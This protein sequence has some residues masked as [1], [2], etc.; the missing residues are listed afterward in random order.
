MAKSI[1]REKSYGFAL[2]VIQ[3]YK[4]LCEEHKEYTLSR[5][6]LKA[7]TSTGANIRE[8]QFAQS[9]PDMI[10][11]YSIALKEI[12]EIEYFEMFDELTE[13]HW[14]TIV[15]KNVLKKR[16]KFCDYF[17]R[18]GWENNLIYQKVKELENE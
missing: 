13:K 16:K 5:Q 10:S 8:G 6:L 18:K 3:V 2:K 15:E 1:L 9:I 12:N 7:G 14:Q 11:K 17:L 4:Q